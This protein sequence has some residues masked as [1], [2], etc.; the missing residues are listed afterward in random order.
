MRYRELQC[1]LLLVIE[2]SKFNNSKT[3]G[4]I[5]IRSNICD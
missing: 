5:I 4:A 2:R 3:K 1:Q